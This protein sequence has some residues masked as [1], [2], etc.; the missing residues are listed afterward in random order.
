MRNHHYNNLKFEM[1][2]R[3][4]RNFCEIMR[5]LGYPRN[6]SME[7]FRNPNFE[8][9]ADILYWFAVRYDPKADIS[10][11]IEGEK[12]RVNFIRAICQLFASKARITLNPKKLY[13]AS[14]FA[15]KEMLKVATM[16]QKAM[17]VSSTDDEDSSQMLD[18]NLS[19]KM[20]NLK[21]A[22][23]LASEI[24]E[25]GAKLHDLLGQEK[26]LKEAREKA[27]EF[28]DSI[29]RNLDTN[30]EQQYIEKAIR[31]IID[32]QTRKM[33]EMEETVKALRQD[34]AELDNKIQRR[35]QELERA[36]KRLKGIEN[37][38]PE[39]QDEYEKLEVELERFYSIYVEKYCN[40]D[41]LESEMDHYNLKEKETGKAIK[42]T[43]KTFQN[44]HDQEEKGG[45]LKD[46]DD[47]PGNQELFNEMRETRTG[48]GKFGGKKEYSPGQ[49]NAEGGLQPD[50]D[51][52]DEDVDE[53]EDE[54]DGIDQDDDED[55]GQDDGNF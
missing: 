29:S 26:E 27:L 3:E 8:L 6:I 18:F 23:Q 41:F 17:K 14:G 55:D 33:S 45:L 4:L 51:D 24:T 46:D 2:F 22:R 25:T 11:D 42:T 30:T 52:E 5:S 15:V 38:K 43:I 54:D 13:E 53:D 9:V 48:F 21:A 35:R 49:H 40:I 39:H 20:N 50:D 34:E 44:A 37:V 28:L 12:E 7:N 32:Q 16:M 1:S 47:E 10:D 19:S 36:E 31:N